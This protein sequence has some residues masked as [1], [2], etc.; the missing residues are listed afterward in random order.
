MLFIIAHE[1]AISSHK[2][3]R[4]EQNNLS[5]T[6]NEQKFYAELVDVCA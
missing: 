1:A 3:P 5:S 4:T 6:A 2:R